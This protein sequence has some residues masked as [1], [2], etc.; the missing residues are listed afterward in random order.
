MV[1]AKKDIVERDG[2]LEYY[3]LEESMSEVADLA[4]LKEWLNKRKNIITDPVRAKQF[5][6][7]FPKGVLLVGVPGCGKSLCAKAVAMEWGL[8]LL[9]LDPGSLYNKYIGE[10]EKNFRRA[11]ST[12]ERIAPVVL[13]IDSSRKPLR[14]AVKTAASRSACSAPSYRGCRTAPAMCSWSHR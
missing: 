7:S 12:A 9:K 13:W 1:A 11:M 3:P 10:T 4:G 8:P 6:L 5:G 2:V 14:R